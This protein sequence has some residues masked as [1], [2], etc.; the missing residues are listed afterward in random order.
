MRNDGA[1]VMRPAVATQTKQ[2]VRDWRYPGDLRLAQWIAHLPVGALAAFI[3]AGDAQLALWRFLLGYGAAV[4]VQNVFMLAMRRRIGPERSSLADLLTLF[5]ADSAALL[6]GLVVAGL[7]DRTSGAGNLAMLALVIGAS[8]CDWLDGP[9]ARRFGP[10]KLGAVLDIE[11]DSWLTLW[12]A[13][14][15]CA[16]GG[17]PWFVI[18]PPLLHY[19]HP[20]QALRHGHLPKGGGPAWSRVTGVAQMLLIAATLLPIIGAARDLTLTIAAYPIS[21]AQAITMLATLRSESARN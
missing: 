10:T 17:L 9:L 11:S 19:L 16:W 7:Q 21:L 18:I 8:A 6:A 15:A 3:V 1:S 14:A 4:I 12:S 20:I 2:S 13:V 5:R